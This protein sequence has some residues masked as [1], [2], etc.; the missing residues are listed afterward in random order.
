MRHSAR[1]TPFARCLPVPMT[2]RQRPVQDGSS[3]RGPVQGR[4]IASRWATRSGA[5]FLRRLSLF[6]ARSRTRPVPSTLQLRPGPFGLSCLRLGAFHRTTCLPL[7]SMP[8]PDPAGET[9]IA[10][11]PPVHQHRG[12]TGRPQ[13]ALSEFSELYIAI[14]ALHGCALVA[15][16]PRGTAGPLLPSATGQPLWVGVGH[17]GAGCQCPARLLPGESSHGS[18]FASA[19]SCSQTSWSGAGDPDWWKWRRSGDVPGP[20]VAL[21][22]RSRQLAVCRLRR[23]SRR[24]P[25][26]GSPSWGPS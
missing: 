8:G 9:A 14:T 25:P 19:Q 1:P 2:T 23:A 13:A 24:F 21:S 10:P 7:T 4:A 16:T 26:G 3:F 15:P 6:A 22:A 5:P 12:M 17:R 11:P 20:G 18:F